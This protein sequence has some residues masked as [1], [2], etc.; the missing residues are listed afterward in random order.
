MKT[1]MTSTRARAFIQGS[2]LVL[3]CAILGLAGC[4]DPTPSCNGC[5]PTT[6]PTPSVPGDLP[7]SDASIVSTRCEATGSELIVTK[8]LLATDIAAHSG[9]SLSFPA[10]TGFVVYWSVCNLGAGKSAAVS[11]PPQGLHING[12]GMNQTFSYSIPALDSCQCVVPI[13]Q[14][15]F[16]SGIATPGSYDLNLVGLFSD[17][18][19]ITIN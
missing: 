8:G 13:P 16:T 14:Q 9:T 3:G 4:G 11:T 5:G 1:N 19:T 7:M 6:N 2:L 15:Q 10:N 18:A 12:P 17:K